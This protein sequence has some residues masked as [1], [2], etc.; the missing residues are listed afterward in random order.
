M[1]NKRHFL[2]FLASSVLAGKSWSQ[3]RGNVT[4]I[5]VPY[6][7]GGASDMLAR[8]IAE[9]LQKRINQAVIIEN[10]PGGNHEIANYYVNSQPANG[11]TLYLI[12]TPFSTAPAANP[13]VHKYHP[14]D[15][16]TPI[17]R[18]TT[19]VTV[20]VASSKFPPKTVQEV[21]DYARAHPGKVQFATTGVGSLDHLLAFRIGKATGTDLNLVHY[22]GAAAAFQDLM[23]GQVDLKIDSYA[24]AKPALDSGRAKLIA[25][26]DPSPSLLLP[27]YKTISATIPGASLV[28]YFG[29]VGPRGMPPETASRL[30]GVLTEI[31]QS[32]AIAPRL[33]QLALEPSPL[34]PDAFRKFLT[35]CYTEVQAT[36]KEA[37]IKME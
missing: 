13:S 30:S 33:K 5:V 27:N 2:S 10:K 4:T 1:I 31:I 12:A 35:D 21:I 20:L 29:M 32:E 11:Q 37:D 24:S 28:S 23:G 17:A 34:A 19:N 3:V 18:L 14:A 36:V 16:F 26:A 9:Q 6:P 22:K 15:S 25:L 8:V 7:P